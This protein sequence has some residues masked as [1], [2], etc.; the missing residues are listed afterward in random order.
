MVARNRFAAQERSA[1]SRLA[2]LL[3][4]HEVICGSVVSMARRCGKAGC[5]C[6]R[7]EKHVSLYLSA[8]VEGKRRMVYI[9]AELEDE[10]RR[11]V[12]AY[13]EVEQLT[14][15]VSAACVDRVLK[16]KREC[17]SHG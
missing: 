4:D 5:H 10:V 2:Q 1:R 3:H 17:K 9:P 6:E 11:R 15:V 8:K 13:R 16:R 12:A 14:E 7:G